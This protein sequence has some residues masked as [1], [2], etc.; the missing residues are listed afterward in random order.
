MW[1][2]LAYR[3]CKTGKLF[4]NW[5]SVFKNL[6]ET[7]LSLTKRAMHLY[8]C[9][10]V[11]DLETHHPSPHVL[12]CRIWSFCVKG[13]RHKY[14]KP[15]NCAALQLRYLRI[16][17]VADPKIYALHHMCCQVKFGSSVTKG[18]RK[19]IRNEPWRNGRDWQPKTSPSPYLLPRKNLVVL[20]QKVY[21]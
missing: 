2:Y 10:G 13:C 15:Q 8:K 6:Q 18:V 11:A 1:Y 12:P 19:K 21:A 5:F 7:Q 16:G 14:G 4:K 20:R 17:G 3:V 9:N